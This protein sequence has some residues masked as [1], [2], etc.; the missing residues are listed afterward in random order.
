MERLFDPSN[1]TNSGKE[2]TVIRKFPGEKVYVK[3]TSFAGAGF[4]PFLTTV[5]KIDGTWERYVKELLRTGRAP[6]RL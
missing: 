6:R 4:E 1:L 2:V 3:F 5:D